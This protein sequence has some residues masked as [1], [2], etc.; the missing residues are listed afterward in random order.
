MNKLKLFFTRVDG[1]LTRI[2]NPGVSGCLRCWRAWT[3]VKGHITEYGNEGKGC[4]PLC[5]GCWVELGPGNRLPFYRTLYNRWLREAPMSGV[6]VDFETI[7]KAVMA[8]E[9]SAS[10]LTAREIEEIFRSGVDEAIK[11]RELP[12]GVGVIINSPWQTGSVENAWYLRGYDYM[13]R[14]G[15]IITRDG[16]ITRMKASLDAGAVAMREAQAAVELGRSEVVK[17]RDAARQCVL[18]QSVLTTKNFDLREALRLL[19]DRVTSPVCMGRDTVDWIEAQAKKEIEAA[20]KALTPEGSQEVRDEREAEYIARAVVE[21]LRQ[22][23]RLADLDE[24]AKLLTVKLTFWVGSAIKVEREANA[25][26][27]I[28]AGE[29]AAEVGEDAAGYVA[30][31]IALQIRTR[32]GGIV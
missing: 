30:C 7:E 3:V 31:D 1:L 28:A 5:R 23:P 32:Q 21:D 11:H 13:A 16:V 14:M 12:T 29:R 20:G 26:L 6:G 9:V 8:E 10:T 27:A 24:L 4:F 2:A 22:G 25:L 17:W 15:A 18:R 19:L